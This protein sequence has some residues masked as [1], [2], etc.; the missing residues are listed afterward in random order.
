MVGAAVL[1][2]LTV[3]VAPNSEFNCVT[4]VLPVPAVPA[5]LLLEELLSPDDEPVLA[6]AVV[7]AA[8]VVAVVVAAVVVAAVL[9]VPP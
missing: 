3:P 8:V 2:T 5:E 4:A 6:A 1:A 7:V 9:V